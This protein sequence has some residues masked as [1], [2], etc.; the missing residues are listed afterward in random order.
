MLDGMKDAIHMH[1]LRGPQA[2]RCREGWLVIVGASGGSRHR[3]GRGCD[4]V[5]Q[6][7]RRPLQARASLPFGDVGLQV[8]TLACHLAARTCGRR[9]GKSDEPA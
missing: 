5:V 9:K 7:L 4:L 8:A 3:D 2:G 1:K 6:R